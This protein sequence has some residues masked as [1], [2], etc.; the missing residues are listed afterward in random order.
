MYVYCMRF[1]IRRRKEVVVEGKKSGEHEEVFIHLSCPVPSIRSRFRTL[2]IQPAAPVSGLIRH[3]A[4]PFVLHNT[5]LP[6]CNEPQRF[7]KKPRQSAH[8][9]VY[10]HGFGKSRSRAH[11]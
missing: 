10:L 5:R 4:L 3:I 9:D 1:G 6:H 11:T 8:T 2:S 7:W